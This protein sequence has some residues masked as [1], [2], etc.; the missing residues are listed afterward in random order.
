M[1]TRKTSPGR[2]G[3]TYEQV[4]AAANA[5]LSAGERATIRAVR[6]RLGGGSPNTIQRH[7]ERWSQDRA[8]AVQTTATLP[9]E[10]Q[11]LILAE[12]GRG[13]AAARAEL[14]QQLADARA[15]NEELARESEE[16]GKDLE[17]V[18]AVLADVQS[19]LQKS[20]GAIEQLNREKAGAHKAADDARQALAKAELKLEALPRIEADLESVREAYMART[21]ELEGCSVE[22]A[23]FKAKAVAQEQQIADLKTRLAATEDALVTERNVGDKARADAARLDAEIAGARAA[24]AAAAAAATQAR[25]DRTQLLELLKGEKPSHR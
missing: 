13:V 2:Q 6:A 15:N 25:Q 16:Q 23:G 9:F 11:R 20:A 1:E 17:S 18:R 14:E 21:K 12:M 22:R 8:P 5:L 3:V 7:L 4:A 19:E 24:L 10:I